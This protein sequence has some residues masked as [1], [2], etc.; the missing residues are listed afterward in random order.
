M[1]QHFGIG[2]YTFFVKICNFHH[3][4][5][6]I[7]FNFN[8][9]ISNNLEHELIMMATLQIVFS[10]N[11]WLTRKVDWKKVALNTMWL[12]NF[13]SVQFYCFP[14]LKIMLSIYYL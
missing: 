13:N 4:I 10:P 11:I 8:L 1:I 6:K 12:M 5:F 2:F 7:N 14:N 9:S 3:H